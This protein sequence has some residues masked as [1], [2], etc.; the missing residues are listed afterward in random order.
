MA[1]SHHKVR[2]RGVTGRCCVRVCSS[3][4]ERRQYDTGL[5]TRLK[6]AYVPQTFLHCKIQGRTSAGGGAKDKMH[7]RQW[8]R[9]HPG[10]RS[11]F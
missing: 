7:S 5:T 11:I 6:M 4:S 3:R 10:S 1:A 8:H 9:Q 2:C